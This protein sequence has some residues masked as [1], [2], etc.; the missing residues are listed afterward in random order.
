[1][2][3]P[4]CEITLA[5][6]TGALVD[7]V[8]VRKMQRAQ[9]NYVAAHKYIKVKGVTFRREELDAPTGTATYLSVR[10]LDMTAEFDL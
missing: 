7:T 9:F 4:L 8:Y 3:T 2:A 10:C 5:F 1:M 6:D